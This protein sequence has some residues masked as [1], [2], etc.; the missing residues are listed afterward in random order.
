MI[1]GMLF[2]RHGLELRTYHF[3]MKKPRTVRRFPASRVSVLFHDR[4]AEIHLS[5]NDDEVASIAS[6]AEDV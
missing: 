4:I 1:V 5:E 2:L 6:N 3:T